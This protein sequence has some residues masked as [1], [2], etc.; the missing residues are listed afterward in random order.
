MNLSVVSRLDIFYFCYVQ[1]NRFMVHSLSFFQKD[2]N[3]D[4]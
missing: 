3:N 1:A 2:L 4:I